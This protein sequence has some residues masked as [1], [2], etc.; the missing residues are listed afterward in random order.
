[1]DALPM[2]SVAAAAWWAIS[3]AL[4][5]TTISAALAHPRLRHRLATRHDRPP[6]SIVIPI[7]RLEFEAEAA[8]TSAFAQVYPQSEILVAAAEDHSP[9]IEIARQVAAQFPAVGARILTGNERITPNPKVSNLAPAIAAAQ[10][11][12]ILIKD[13]NILLSPDQLA[14]LMTNLTAGVGLVCAIPVAVAPTGFAAELERAFLNGQAAPL[15]LALSAAGANVGF[16]KVMLFDRRDLAR[17]GGIGLMASA[18]GDDHA[19]SQGLARLGLRTVF[20]AKEIRQ[21][22]GRRPFSEVWDRHQRWMVIRRIQASLAFCAEPLVSGAFTALCGAV[23]AAAFGMPWWLM[24]G[25]TL[26]GWV[27][28]DVTF[29][30]A[31]GWGWSW[32]SPLSGLCREVLLPVMWLKALLDRRVTWAGLPFD[33]PAKTT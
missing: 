28:L 15:T 16:G 7:R 26:L 6:V 1:M 4:R 14:D 22:I 19:L 2:L 24:A 33:V 21:P 20:A 11:D 13:S 29:F 3:C 31:K 25:A 8:F 23:G 10:H 27:L 5:I 17:A 30:A 12:L 32:M 9:M 18:F